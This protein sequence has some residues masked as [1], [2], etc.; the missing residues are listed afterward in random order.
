MSLPAGLGA[1]AAIAAGFLASVIWYQELPQST[2]LA[3]PLIAFALPTRPLSAPRRSTAFLK[4]ST[5]R[6]IR[7]H[8]TCGY[9]SVMFG[10]VVII[11]GLFLGGPTLGL[12]VGMTGLASIAWL[13][14]SYRRQSLA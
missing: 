5:E 1:Y 11:S 12:I 2:A 7:L 6:W 14:I 8:R 9:V 10:T 13:A 3:R 4:R